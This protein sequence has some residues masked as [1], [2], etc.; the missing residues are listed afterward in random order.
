PKSGHR[1]LVTEPKSGSAG[2]TQGHVIPG[3]ATSE[4]LKDPNVEEIAFEADISSTAVLTM[5][6]RVK[7]RVAAEVMADN[8]RGYLIGFRTNDT[9]P[10]AVLESVRAARVTTAGNTI[11]L[12]MT[13]TPEAMQRLRH[14]EASSAILTW[15][16]GTE[17]RD[18][19]QRVADITKQLSIKP[20]SQVADVGS[21]DGYLSVRL[22]RIVGS[23]GKV[24]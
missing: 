6:T 16:L 1:R 4:W 5:R 17:D 19:W 18:R 23:G 9:A 21:G 8:L 24:F 7:T 3:K 20:G 10:A 14:N 12:S 2:A 22:A 15:H 13:F 11:Q